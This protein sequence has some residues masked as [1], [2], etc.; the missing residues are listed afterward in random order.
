MIE[1]A[2]AIRDAMD[3]A[4]ASLD[5]DTALICVALYRPWKVGVNYKVN[6]RF[7]YGVNSVGDPQL[8]RVAQAH[9][10]QD[11]W[12]PDAVP[13]LYHTP[14]SQRGGLPHLDTAHRRT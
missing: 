9:T 6:D 11:D 14:R 1:Q 13:A 5:E 3:Y 4:G 12:R 7:T 2:K 8:Y 10:S